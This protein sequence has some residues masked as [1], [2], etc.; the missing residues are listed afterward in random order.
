[1][2]KF[3][4]ALSALALVSSLW[5]I[6]PVQ[7]QTT[8][9]N[10]NAV[11]AATYTFLNSDCD[12]QGRKIVVFNNASGVTVT[13]PQ[14][15][16]N[17]A[18]FSG[19]TITVHNAGLGNVTITPTVSTINGSA[20]LV[21]QSGASTTINTDNTNYY[22]QGGGGAGNVGDSFTNFR[23]VLDNGGMNV[24]QRGTAATNCAGTSG[25]TT[26]TY[27]ADRWTCI[28]NVGS[29]AGQSQVVTATPTPPTGFQNALNVWRNSAALTQP[30]DR[31]SVV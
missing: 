13:L 20:V 18:F 31:K 9:G 8:T 21:A 28:V 1:M 26:T 24:A 22:A 2:K 12:P 7:A 15:G 6:N 16:T 4:H 25:S 14:A 10:I 23:N 30:V 11:T 19:C 17:G 27:S 5:P 3:F 29:Q